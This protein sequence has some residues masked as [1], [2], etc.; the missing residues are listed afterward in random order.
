MA[1]FIAFRGLRY[2]AKAG[3]L[4]DVISPPY[5]IIAPAEREALLERSPHNVV[6]VEF[7]KEQPGDSP[8]SD[9]YTRARDDLRAWSR[10][11]LLARDASPSFYVT[12]HEFVVDDARAVR[13][14]LLGALRVYPEGSPAVLPHERTIPKDKADRLS[15]IRTALAN[16]S[17]IFGLVDD[18]DRRLATLL[19]DVM[20]GAPAA[21]ARVGDE[22]HRLWPV[23]GTGFV[24]A[25]EAL[26][27][28]KTVYLA[29]GH[30]R[31]ETARAFLEEERAAGRRTGQA[32][33]AAFVL[34]YLCALDDPGLRI[35]TSDRVVRGAIPALQAAAAKSFEAGA[36]EGAPVVLVH[37]GTRT[38][39]RLRPGVDRSALPR[40]WNGVGIGEAET[41]LLEPARAAGAT[42]TYTHRRDESI[43]QAKGDVAAVLVAPVDGAL[44]KRV[45]DMGERLPQKTTYFYPKVPAGLV[46]RPL[47]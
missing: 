43:S 20:R 8:T 39:L 27:R 29:D 40:A 32:D 12:E 21:D 9:K 1:D 26:F 35:F 23:D 33:S 37:D 36:P 2:T 15:L 6:R 24:G 7:G 4:A 30:H 3:S 31:Y 10:D 17:P 18:A 19:G 28:E 46:I 42:V 25:V 11:G 34:C 44:I 14:G 41:F 5:D 47:D 16:T 45:S 13:R 22:R 38:G